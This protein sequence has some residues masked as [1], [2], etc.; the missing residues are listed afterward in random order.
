MVSF[1]PMG[2][3]LVFQGEM[4][5]FNSIVLNF[6][7]L[8]GEFRHI[9]AG[10]YAMVEA[11]K[12]NGK[13]P[14]ESELAEI[15]RGFPFLDG[16][17]G[18]F[19]KVRCT[20]GAIV[21]D[22]GVRFYLII[23]SFAEVVKHTSIADGFDYIYGGAS[24]FDENGNLATAKRIISHAEKTRYLLQIAKGLELHYA[25]PT[26]VY[27]LSHGGRFA[28]AIPGGSDDLRRR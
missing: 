3:V 15:G 23:A 24:H 8:C 7:M 5:K 18:M 26:E 13:K 20:A 17:D 19:D 21:K 9:Q 27:R 22:I 16:V 14:T 4:G 11:L 10:A 6:R 2:S 25:N 12:R 28:V 1:S